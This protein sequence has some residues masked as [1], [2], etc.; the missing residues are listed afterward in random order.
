MHRIAV[1]VH[2]NPPH[3][4]FDTNLAILPDI[5]YNLMADSKFA[6][7]KL[8]DYIS[9][10]Q[11]KDRMVFADLFFIYF[12]LPLCLLFYFGSHSIRARNAVLL[13][14]S[15]IFYAWGEPVWVLMLI[16]YSYIN[17]C[18]GLLIGRA[19][20]KKRGARAAK[21]ALLI[22]V[23]LDLG[24]LGIFKYSGFFVENINA[25]LHLAIPVP[26]IR[27]PIG[28]SFYTFQTLSYSIDC[29][30]GNVKVQR[31]FGKFLLYVSMFPQLVAGPIVRYATIAEEIADRLSTMQDVSE[32][33]SRIIRG[34]G[35]KVIIANSLS[36]VVTGCFGSA[37]SGYQGVTSVSALGAL[38]GAAA[39]ALQ[40]YFDFSG[41]SDIAIGLGRIFGFHF[42]ENFRYPYVCNSI[43]EFWRRWHISL[44]SWFR[45]YVY[46]PL[47]GNRKGLLRQCIN[48]MIVWAL[49]G[50]WHGASWNFML[51]GIYFGVLLLIEKLFLLRTLDRLP[52]WVGHVYAL[53]FVT[54]GWGIFHFD[55]LGALGAF[56]RALLCLNGNP[57]SSAV[58]RNLLLSNLFL[59][60]AAVL[61]SAP[62]I[63]GLRKLAE[64]TAR[65]Y[66]LYRS[67]HI[68]MNLAI[69]G[70]SSMMLVN[71][72]NN[73]F[74]YFRF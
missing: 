19:R 24:V 5:C 10:L 54:L 65:S 49:T 50:F 33:F 3:K 43:T 26:Q 67:L 40:Y 22:S 69:L 38:L 72:T 70:L 48:I 4:F 2:G 20:R 23:I 16:A 32:G 56:F 17:Y 34:I 8:S 71:N 73:P 46:I 35:K 59:L 58:T 37:E 9:N 15:L 31:S 18:T 66:Y 44:S 62:V 36:T 55:D 7:C 57:V 21:A 68:V 27:L 14:F 47:G 11:V 51:W 13:V 12:F 30:R 39:V 45:D 6:C 1:L 28:I 53:F 74:L 61:L 60:A 41:Y 29:Y 25:L 63:D 42:D 52:K 64:K